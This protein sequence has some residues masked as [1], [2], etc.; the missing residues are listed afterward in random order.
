[1]SESLDIAGTAT[2]V[3]SEYVEYLGKIERAQRQLAA[4]KSSEVEIATTPKDV[5]HKIDKGVLYRYRPRETGTAITP[6]I[7]IYGL[8]GRQTMIDLQE[9]RS[10]VRN[11]VDRGVDLYEVNWGNP[12]RADR[13]LTLDDYIDG[14]IDEY[15]DFV[16][17]QTGADKVNIF[18]ICEGGT[19]CSA[20]AALYPQKVKNLVLTITPIDFHADQENEKLE[21]G[22]INVWSRNIGREVLDDLIDSN[23]CMPGEFMS[24]VFQMMTPMRSLTKYNMDLVEIAKDEKTLLNFL[25]MEKWIADRPDH[26]AEAAKQWFKDYY[27]DN[28]LVKGEVV[29]ADKQVDL[30]NITMPVL[31][32]FATHDHIIPPTCSSALGKYVG[33]DDYTDLEVSAG[34]VGLFVSGKS[35]KIV[36]PSII[37]WLSERN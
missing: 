32:V 11:M 23:G 20:Y 26:P 13:W 8:I 17:K 33:T 10:L 5:V 15:V 27:L 34:H 12:S 31:N 9:N 30:A 18:G 14:Y 16:R 7:I 19:F 28:K 29:I 1:M 4:I 3:F 37:D 6:T 35:Q 22:F 36:A 25:R 24:Y 21:H 2:S